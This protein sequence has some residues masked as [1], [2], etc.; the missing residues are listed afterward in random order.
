MRT[1][2]TIPIASNPHRQRRATAVGC[3][4]QPDLG[5]KSVL[6]DVLELR[7]S[8]Q[9]AKT[10]RRRDKRPRREPNSNWAAADAPPYREPLW[11]SED[12]RLSFRMAEK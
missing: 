8:G 5:D 6:A 2:S 10:D 1:K 4:G 7:V 3:P 12:S 9:A 11:E